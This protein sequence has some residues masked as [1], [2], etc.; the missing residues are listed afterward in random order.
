[1]KRRN[2]L[3]KTI[4]GSG[5][6]LAGLPVAKAAFGKKKS[7]RIAHIT[8]V[9]IRPENDIP[10]RAVETLETVL[11]H[12][13]DLFLNGGDSIHDASYDDVSRERVLEQ[14]EEW[15]RFVQMVD[16]Y[17][18]FSC[19]GNHDMWWKAPS[20]EDDMYGKSYAVKRLG[21]PDRYYSVSRG[22]WHFIILDSNQS[23]IRLDD[24]QFQWLQKELEMLPEKTPVLIM[25]HYP[26]LGV[27][28][29]FV[30]GQHS[31][32]EELKTLF[33]AHQDKVKLCLSGHQH[34]VDRAWYNGV[35][36][37][38]NGSMSGYWWGKG[39][40][41]SAG[42]GYYLESPPGYAILDLFEDGTFE[43]VYFPHSF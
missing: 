11:Q 24:G 14:W 5:A 32:F 3:K 9:H 38:C 25:S 18:V 41:H 29:H 37:L 6:S 15:D 16:S 26:I 21:M 22:G 43:N 4:L 12:D 40:E 7:M 35:D 28:D 31:D 1:M 8:D 13:V 39:D 19:L 42:K 20:E 30:G 36:Y 33:Y 10:R 23:G 34:M 27:T 2:W 17:E